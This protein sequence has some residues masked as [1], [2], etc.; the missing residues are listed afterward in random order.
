MDHAFFVDPDLLGD[1]AFGVALA[2]QLPD[3]ALGLGLEGVGLQ[4]ALSL[5]IVLQGGPV[6]R[7]A[8]PVSKDAVTPFLQDAVVVGGILDVLEAFGLQAAIPL[9]LKLFEV[10]RAQGWPAR[11]QVLRP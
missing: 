6:A 3:A 2:V 5:F 11:W 9:L 7:R 10:R 1:L 8:E 4:N